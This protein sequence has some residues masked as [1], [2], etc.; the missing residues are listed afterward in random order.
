MEKPL[1]RPNNDYVF[2]RIFGDESNKK[3]V[4]SLLRAILEIE[5][6]DVVLLPQE[7]PRSN[8]LIKNAIL[9]IVAHLDDGTII[10]IEM[11]VAFDEEYI[12]RILYY[13]AELFAFQPIR[14]GS[15]Y[16]LKKTISITILNDS[17]SFLPHPHS[18]YKLMECHCD[19]M[20]VLTDKEEFHFIDV[21]R[22]E[23][24]AKVESNEKLIHWMKF[25]TSKT[26]EEMKVLA[27]QDACIG[28]A[29]QRLE[30]MSLDE[31]EVYQAWA[32]EKFLVDQERRES[33]AEKKGEKRGIEIGEKK[34]REEGRE[35]GIEIGEK[36]GTIQT[37]KAMIAAGVDTETVCKA[38][39]LS[40]DD[41]T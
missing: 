22:V 19:P 36:K 5:I 24:V 27:E 40:P 16:A 30:I 7:I 37:A 18:F 28:R 29:V 39:G 31:N 13:W 33:A 26:R 23:E 34:G 20:H 12:D 9:D 14:G 35:E 25:F 41:L 6:R 1:L 3:V 32:R 4:I 2:K 15:H 38:T 8:P 17:K 21:R 11:Q 10:D